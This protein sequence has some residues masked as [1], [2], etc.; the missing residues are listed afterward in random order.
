MLEV[1]TLGYDGGGNMI[2]W[3]FCYDTVFKI[4]E[5]GKGGDQQA[6]EQRLCRDAENTYN[7]LAK[8]EGKNR[9]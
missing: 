7:L 2:Q 1:N 6:A 3:Y 4:A 8:P 5:L 9:I